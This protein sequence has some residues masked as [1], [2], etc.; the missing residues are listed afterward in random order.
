MIVLTARPHRLLDECIRR[1]GA[2]IAAGEA[3]MFIVPSQYTLQA[4][5]EIMDRLKING[6][7]LV[8]VLSP[9]RLKGRVFERA[10]APQQ[11]VFDE[12][13]KRMVLS[14]IIAQEKDSLTIYRSA[15]ASGSQGFAAKVSAM[16]ADFKRSGKTAQDVLLAAEQLEE[17]SP[18]RLKLQDAARLYAAYEISMAGEL[19]DEEDVSME[20][21][22]RLPRSHILDGQHVFV[23]GF[24]M[25]T[26]VFAAELVQ[27]V[28]L[29]RSL[30]L[31]VETDANAAP[32]GRL[33]APVNLSLD[34]LRK[35][36]ADAGIAVRSEHITSDRMMHDD[37]AALERGLYAIGGK[38]A[39]GAAVHIELRAA[40]SMRAEVHLAASRIRRLCREGTAAERISVVYPKGGGYA[41]LLM[42]ILPM[43][44]LSVYA[45][46]KRK[47][48]GHPL[49]RLVLSSLAV[50][51][52]GFRTA[53]VM[54]CIHTGFFGL[55]DEQVDALCAYA[56]GCG[57]RL[58]GWK[59]PFTYMKE[60]NEE[61]LVSL[62]TARE[63]VVRP[64]MVFAERMKRAVSADDTV[65]AVIA[66]L[67]ELGAYETLEQM[68]LG[69][70]QAGLLPEADDCAQ[71][72][73]ALMETLDQLH[74]LLSGR[75]ASAELA[76]R[77][78][79]EGLGA[80]ELSALPPADG[81]IICGEIGNVRT[82]EIDVLFAVGMND[83][84]AGLDASLLTPGEQETAAQATG[85]YLGMTASERA[86]LAQLDELK[87]L[88]G[89]RERLIVSYALADE[90]GRALREGSAVQALRRLFPSLTVTGGLAAQE[91][92]EMYT[93]MAP[94]L[95]ALSVRLSDA[96]D[97][98]TELTQEDAQA[99][100]AIAAMDGGQEAL[101]QITRR[102][103]EPAERRLP[104]AGAK[105]L[106]GR[107]VMSV[108]RLETFAQC[109]YKHFVRYGLAPQRIQE[110]GVD[111]AELGTLYH[112]A[113]E[114]FTQR[115]TQ[116]PSFPEV[117]TEDCDRI[118]DDAVRPLLDE[119]RGSPL[120]QSAR[121][122]GIARRIGRTARR[123]GRN[124]VRQ[125][126]GSGFRP[127]GS[128]LV[129]G[130]NGAAPITLEMPDGSFVYLQGR[131]DRIDVY[132]GHT[133]R[134]V[135]YKSGFKKFDPTMAYWG[136]QL[137][138]L[139]Y[140]AAAMEE[141]GGMQAGG[142][143]YCRI[144]D[145]TVKTESRIRE[146]VEKQIA[147][148]LEL[149]GVSLADVNI[150]RAQDEHHAGM[151]TKDGQISGRHTASLADEEGMGGMVAFAR[152]KAAQLAAQAYS[153]EIADSPA[154]IGQFDACA[155]CSYTAI[156]RFDPA[157][158]EKRRLAKK[159]I[160][161]LR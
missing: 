18:I 48:S 72:W 53:D 82:A 161:D 51:A 7:F 69:L 36:A 75:H 38:P 124:I 79:E 77:L 149:A 133:I 123:T 104:A 15:A 64:L 19:A 134:V 155:Q 9:G 31:A 41:P 145:P 93:A 25:I 141:L 91:Q 107:P 101:M 111:R 144:A 17:G 32:D 96:A 63:A 71:V 3:C 35:T 110:P 44:G 10:G 84:P 52:G 94:A 85:A 142:F 65:A 98:R 132:D 143:F 88:C 21:R 58:D 109:P 92:S 1:I 81:A 23:Y 13:G 43:Y 29:A 4:E 34:R 5:L 89:A 128:E 68:Q 45:A 118:M 112:A 37:L 16:I 159:T 90:T 46:E 73:N 154:V 127:M 115:V 50:V 26:P 66:L 131:I 160:A 153:G 117:S 2:L 74:T 27:M 42:N 22:R 125:F 70:T 129:F 113:A 39:D 157:T 62:N 138:L 121:G 80:L 100:A 54:E 78:L 139:I 12:R 24:D 116:L 135:D 146:E 33:F 55:C 103:G 137:Q 136:I 147:K 150:L 140:L 14:E 106:Y 120:G 114:T 11:T 57:L 99:Y 76:G 30:T 60:M 156:C 87:A 28:S 56:E 59:R 119:W 47:A 20:M 83:A 148:K 130:Q 8:D 97:G 86:A 151:I 108:S 95:E 126:A 152:R 158:M 6:S 40:S 122:E 61:A 105:A 49:C 102:L 67:D